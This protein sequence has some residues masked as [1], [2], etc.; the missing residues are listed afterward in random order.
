[1]TGRV[2]GSLDDFPF[3]QCGQASH[4]ELAQ[5][6]AHVHLLIRQKANH[7]RHKSADGWVRWRILAGAI[8]ERNLEAMCVNRDIPVLGQFACGTRVVEVSMG[9]KDRGGRHVTPDV[10]FHSFENVLRIALRS[11]VDEDPSL[12]VADDVAVGNAGWDSHHFRCNH[13][14]V[15]HG[16]PE[17]REMRGGLPSVVARVFMSFRADTTKRSQYRPR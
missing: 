12:T 6:W 15:A 5:V 3:W 13:F 16:S 2:S 8:Q 17:I 11:G 1:M 4:A 14:G 10:L 7:L 9:K